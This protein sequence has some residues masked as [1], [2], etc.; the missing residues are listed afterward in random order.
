M[1]QNIVLATEEDRAEILALYDAQKGR[2]FCP[3]SEDYPS[4][5]EISFDLSRDALYVL[6]IDGEIKAAISI[7][8]DEDVNNLPYWNKELEPEGERV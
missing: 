5:D 8:E 3:W 1:D 4:N 7:E 2:E 6:K